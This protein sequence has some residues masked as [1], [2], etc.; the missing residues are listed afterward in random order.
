MEI[1]K[2]FILLIISG[3]C[4]SLGLIKANKYNL[5]VID[6]MEIKKA[7]NLILTRIRYTYEPLPELFAEVS[8]NANYNISE[9]FTNAKAKM[10]KN[11]IASEAWKQA[12]DESSN[13]F[14]KEDINVIKGLAKLLGQTDLE[15]QV[16]QINLTLKLL[17]EQIIQA[18][19]EKVKNTK[20]YKTL[21]ATVGL[22][23]MI[24]F[25]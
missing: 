16:S 22:A 19:Q 15:G 17:E 3:L 25:I 21:G 12:V 20:L 6:L 4:V 7:L 8:K 13:N 14:S 11:I 18:N 2:F 9:I 10:D 1:F 5:R 23:I 24:I